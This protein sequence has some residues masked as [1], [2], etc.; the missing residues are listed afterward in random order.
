MTPAPVTH[1]HVVVP[2][3]DEEELLPRALAA[4]AEATRRLSATRPEVSV[5]VTAVLDACRD[6]SAAV[7]SDHPWVRHVA[8]GR[9]NVG[10]ARRAGIAVATAHLPHDRHRHWVASTDADCVVGPDWLVDHV[11]LAD[12]GADLVT[13]TVEPLRE[14]LDDLTARRWWA[15]HEVREGHPH[16]HGANLGVRLTAYDDAGG[17]EAVRTHED[18]G[19]VQRVRAGGWTCVASAAVHIG[20]SGRLVGRAP[21]GFAAFLAALTTEPAPAV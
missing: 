14:D 3:H 7:V 12:A 20:T 4:L 19:L 6:T 18:V 13:G 15:S 21:H 9:N 5:D 11:R 17:F 2:V 8:I 1:V 16:V 10:A